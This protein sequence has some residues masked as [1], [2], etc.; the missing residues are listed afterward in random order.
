L[1]TLPNRSLFSKLLGQSTAEA[2]RAGRQ[3][4]VLFL[5]LDRFKHINDTLGHE[6]G[7]EL[8]QEVAARL[9]HC[10][11]ESDL[12]ARLGGDEFVALL[13]E[14]N[15]ERYAATVAQKILA[16]IA[17]PFLLLGQEF[18]ITASIGISIY[19]QDGL[20][21]QTLTKNADIAMY[22]A[23]E[24]GKNNFQFY[25][26]SLNSNSLE[27]LTLESGL[28]HALEGE[29]FRLHY[30]AKWD[31]ATG[32][33]T[34]MEALL[35]WQHPDLGTVAPMQFIKVAEETGLIVPIGKWVLRTACLQNMAWQEQ[36]L[37]QLRMAVNLTAR[38]FFDEHLLEDLG[39]ILAAA[40]MA[41][42]LLEL[43]ISETLLMRDVEKTLRILAALKDLGI[44]IAIDDFGIGYSSLSTLQQFPVDTIKIDQSFIRDISTDIAEQDLA[45]AI[46]AMGR[47]LSLTVVAQ[48]VETKEQADYLRQKAC[49]EIQGF[50]F[51]RP[52]PADQISRLLLAQRPDIDTAATRIVAA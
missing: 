52:L 47:T 51:K 19:P 36:G 28:R 16:A 5:D 20:D 13:P 38:Q 29:E 7:D 44:R 8:L 6:A 22:K 41:P 27:R 21:E 40:R 42:H 25:S 33:I 35:R 2:R 37:P 10:L 48:G 30:Q 49:D 24:E 46:I 18:R 34:G 3:M 23:K 11:R 14:L 32:R 4:A 39:A 50:Y 45:G 15:E 31:I 26:E 43:E 1:T 17:R 9:K 12:V